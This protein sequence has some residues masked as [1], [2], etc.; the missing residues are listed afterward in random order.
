MSLVDVEAPDDARFPLF[1]DAVYTEA[2]LGPGDAVRTDSRTVTLS[3][4]D[5]IV[6]VRILSIARVHSC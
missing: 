6:F 2:I 1:K 3:A 4:Q 5:W